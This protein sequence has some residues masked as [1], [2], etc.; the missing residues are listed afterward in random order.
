[1]YIISHIVN[2]EKMA[3]IL[4]VGQSLMIENALIEDE[5]WRLG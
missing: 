3:I 2:R 1:V 4:T 5:E